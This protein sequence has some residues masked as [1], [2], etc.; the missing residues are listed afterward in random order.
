MKLE[1]DNQGYDVI[2]YLCVF[3][4]A[5]YIRLYGIPFYRTKKEALRSISLLPPLFLRRAWDFG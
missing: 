4:V 5:A 2:W 1:T 3:L